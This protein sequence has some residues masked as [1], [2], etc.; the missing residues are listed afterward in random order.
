MG[1]DMY[2]HKTKT[3]PQSDVDFGTNNFNEEELHY[4]RKHPNL[5]GWMEHLYYAKGGNRDSFNCTNVLLSL[6]DLIT[7]EYDIN[8]GNL[9]HTSGFFFGESDD[10][11]MVDDLEFVRNAKEAIADGYSVYYS[12]WW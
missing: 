4:W 1:L 3:I 2:A 12:S 7:L 11:R 9:P 10:G 8:N 6:D 5:H